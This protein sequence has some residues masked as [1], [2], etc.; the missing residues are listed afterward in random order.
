MLLRI[1]GDHVISVQQTWVPFDEDRRSAH[2]SVDTL[3]TIAVTIGKASTVCAS[4]MAP[5]VNNMPRI[6]S[7]PE[8]ER[9]T[10]RAKP[11]TTGGSPSNALNITTRICRPGKAK[12][13]SAAPN[14]APD[15]AA[16]AVAKALTASERAMM[17]PSP[18]AS[19]TAHK[20][21]SYT[22]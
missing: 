9:S 20:S 4:T 15:S 11:T 19:R 21:Q 10:Y 16:N 13:A 18:P 3:C 1:A 7:G 6:P 8:R 14:G 12:T 2:K 22:D 17:G 5:G